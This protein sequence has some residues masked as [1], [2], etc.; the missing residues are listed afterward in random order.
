MAQ[1]FED[2]WAHGPVRA[3]RWG[4]AGPRIF[5]GVLG[6]MAVLAV[7]PVTYPPGGKPLVSLALIALMVVTLVEM[8]KHDRALCE[9]CAAD[10]PLNPAREAETYRRRLATAHLLS[11]RRAATWYLVAV[12]VACLLPVFAP[13]SLRTP[14]LALW[15]ASLAS[16]VYLMQSGVTHR[17][18]QPWCPHCGPQGGSDQ[19]ETPEPTP[20]DSMGG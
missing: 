14:A 17:R 1:I 12:L 5:A 11:E 15:L 8:R 19:V 10:F 16:L 9:R 4:H 20:L 3:S 2:G 13:P 18:L 7:V 6:T